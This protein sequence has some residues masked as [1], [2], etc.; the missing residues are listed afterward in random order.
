MNDHIHPGTPMEAQLV[1]GGATFRTWAPGA[2]EVYVV[3]RDFDV[4]SPTGWKKNDH[5]L[6]IRDANGYWAG[7][8]PGVV[9]GGE[10]R[11]W[12]VGPGGE[13]FKRDPY[14]R[15]LQMHGYPDCNCIVRDPN[16]FPWRD[17]AFSPPSFNDLIIYQFHI[18]VFYAKDEHGRDIRPG[19]VSKYLDVVDRIKYL[20]D[21]GVNAI[22]PL[23]FVEFQGENSLGYN[24]TDLFSPEMDYAVDSAD[25]EPYLRRVNQLLAEKNFPPLSAA[26]LTGQVNQLK[27]LIELSH[28]YGLAV[29]ADVV[30][31]H[32]GGNFD[33]QSIHFF[34][35]PASSDNKDSI[36]FL[37]DG[38]AGGLIFAFGKPEVR[39]FLIDNAKMLL[40]EY[41]V[42]GFRYDQ[43]TVIDEHGGWFFCQDLTGTLRFIKPGAI[44]IAEYWGNERWRGVVNPPDGMG[45]DAGYNDELRDRIRGVIEQSAGGSSS[46]INL[47]GLREALAPPNGFLAAWKAFQCIENHDLIDASHTGGDKQPRI[48]TLADPSNSRSWYA[49]SRSRVATGL[50]LTAPGIP[51]IF[52]GQEFLEDKAWT[53]NPHA[54]NLMIWWAGLEGLDK[55]MS[56][57]HRFTR[58]LIW[59]R[60]KQPALRAET[61][62]VFHVHND[63]RVI[64]FHRWLPGVG[65]DVVIVA[66]LNESTFYDHSYALGF[67]GDGRWEE[68]FNS[69]IYDNFLNPNAHGNFGGITAGGPGMHGLP[70]SAGVT[71][72]ANSILAFARDRSDVE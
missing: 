59:L 22:M 29:I 17:Q 5:D 37:R 32:A 69:D 66:S 70:S 33:D 43:V 38:H 62:N 58:D 68:V 60:R 44:Q 6:L 51:M 67:P 13:G 57:H 34:D 63:N 55:S 40:G 10:Y 12:I 53:D 71:L 35:R 48:A 31:N 4:Q 20:A 39:Q 30:Y 7:F 25:L 16:A 64:A 36:Y 42:D 52:M 26:Q 9:D 11:F 46:R 1:E 19:R 8:F 23:P 50:L 54:A 47:E 61:I 2:K 28:L 18:G 56:D 65:R 41:H 14:A 15:E 27:A 24:G 21:L 45:F 3:L 72:P 49:R